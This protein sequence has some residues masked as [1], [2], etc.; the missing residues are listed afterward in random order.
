MVAKELNL[1]SMVVMG[2]GGHVTYRYSCYGAIQSLS[3]SDG[4]HIESSL[5]EIEE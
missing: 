2:G 5:G 1:G 3:E 4:G